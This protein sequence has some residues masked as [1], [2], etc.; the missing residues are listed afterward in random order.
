MLAGGCIHLVNHLPRIAHLDQPRETE[1]ATSH[2]LDQTLDTRLIAR[3]K[4]HRLV[5]AEAADHRRAANCACSRRLPVRSSPRQVQREDRVLPSRQQSLQIEF[6]QFQKITFGCK[7]AAGDQYVDVRMPVKKFAMSL[8]RRHHAG[9]HILAAEPANRFGLEARPGTSREFAQQL[10][11]EPSVQPK[12]LGDGQDDLPMRDWKTDFFGNVD[13][14]QQRPLLVA[15]WAGTTLLAGEGDKP[16]T[17]L[18][19][20]GACSPGSEL[21]Q[22]LLADRHT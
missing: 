16:G 14:G 10:A 11:V 17:M 13:R 3:R 5:H 20:V 18:C 1:G 7:R 2:V 12:T 19:M 4:K 6:G 22:S 8:N 21:G 9:C 15:G